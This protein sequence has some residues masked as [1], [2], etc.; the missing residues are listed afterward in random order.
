MEQPHFYAYRAGNFAKGLLY[1]WRVL[2]QSLMIQHVYDHC[3]NS[4]AILWQSPWCYFSIEYVLWLLACMLFSNRG[5]LASILNSWSTGGALALGTKKKKK[6]WLRLL[7][8]LFIK[9]MFF[10]VFG[11]VLFLGLLVFGTVFSLKLCQIEA[12]GIWQLFAL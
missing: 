8:L 12:A 10:I 1:H 4:H 3:F 7:C 2:S 9:K 5:C 11:M 6:N